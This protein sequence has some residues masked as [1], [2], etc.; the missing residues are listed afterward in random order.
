[1]YPCSFCE[2]SYTH[3]RSLEKHITIKHQESKKEKTFCEQC[4]IQVKENLWVAH[5]RT[6]MHKKN[7]M[8]SVNSNN[9]NIKCI[10]SMFT[11][12]IETYVIENN[13]PNDL[14]VENFFEKHLNE[15]SELLQKSIEKHESIK[16]NF[17][18]FCKYIQIKENIEE[19][20][21]MSHQT[22]MT[23]AFM[24]NNNVIDIIKEKFAKLIEKIN[25]FQERDSG[26]S[27]SEIIHLEVNINKYQ[28]I[29]GSL[30][31]PLPKIIADKKACINIVNND[32]YCFKWAI[33]S[34]L[35]QPSI[36]RQRC[37]SYNI[38]NIQD[39][40]ITLNNGKVVNFKNLNFPLQI[41]DIKIFEANNPNI[42]VN[43]F[44]IED[45]LLVGPFYLTKEEKSH[46]VN[47]I[48]L[49]S[50]D[51]N[52]SH[53]VW[54]Q[55]LSRLLSSQVTRNMH[56][57]Y[58]C[59]SC[60]IHFYEEEKLAIHKM[61]CRKIVTRMPSPE[62]KILK[63][64]N[65]K[66]QIDVPFTIYAD[67]ECILKPIDIQNSSRTQCVQ[68][69][70]P[71]AYCYFIKCSYNNH[72]NRFKIYSGVDA[73]KHFFKNIF[74]DVIDIYHQ[75]LNKIV[76]M[77]PLTVDQLRRQREDIVCHICGME[78]L[79]SDRVADHC[80]LTGEYRGP[81]HKKCNLEY[82]IANFIP[83]FFHNL[84]KYDCHLFIKEL[85]SVKG[86]INIIPLNKEL[87]ISISKRI[88][89]NDKDTIELRF[90]DSF[91]FMP[92]SL[93]SLAKNLN[94]NDLEITKTFFPNDHHFDLMK[95]KGIFPYD[96]LDSET[97]LNETQLPARSHFF[98]KLSNES[99]S[100]EDYQYAQNV[101]TTFN[102]SN[103]LD[104]L[105]LYLKVDVLLLSDIFENFRKLCK[106]IYRLDPCQYYTSPG[107]SW[108]AMLK[109]TRTELE[110]FTDENMHNFILSGI[111]GGI[112]QCCKRHSVAN[113]KYLS[114]YNATKPSNFIIYLDVNNLYGY[115]MSH[116]LPHSNFEWVENVDDF[117]VFSIPEDS[118]VGYILEVDLDYP[119]T[120]HNIH[121]DFPLCFENKK[122]G[123]MKNSKL[124]GD[125]GNKDY[126]NDSK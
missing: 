55:N 35:Y 111:R 13:Q 126:Q 82:Q 68:E 94:N 12:R 100:I 89:I 117:N 118:L 3:K 69:H 66:K 121:N 20:A 8:F 102:C 75:F 110:L 63:F 41:K 108:D 70:I 21:I 60:L 87:Y 31:I 78:L 64:E 27:L 125:L 30:Y 38:R 33:V 99:C 98:N 50:D 58:F 116:N 37:S 24:E 71:Y 43:V 34:S 72:L 95:R 17:E 32:V 52:E 120:T 10:N 42:S 114:D 57:L 49:Y 109:I 26:W 53:Y 62:K 48:S 18:L 36:N 45:N 92:S 119:I 80:H 16:F 59:N 88:Y 28:P 83:I 91:R 25:T 122:I 29:R 67:F 104:Y 103:L 81:A 124:I 7:C 54:I 39:S 74:D 11:N 112:V 9:N 86:D 84:S 115:A 106:G 97:C 44:G 1:M 22:V 96:Y 56:K 107:L 85:S 76:G 5:V 23:E 79:L 6:N 105:L 51:F 61:H 65:F 2:K 19:F 123:S 46:H 15:L 77:H 90:L 14:I 73:S 47:L 113:N 101:W 4:K 93:D 40:I